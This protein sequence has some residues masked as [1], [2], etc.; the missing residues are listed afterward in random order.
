[1]TRRAGVLLEVLL[2]LAVF[3]GASLTLTRV[4]SLTLSA[5]RTAA[6]EQRATDIARTALSL[7]EIGAARPETL[8]GPADPMLLGSPESASG[9]GFGSSLGSDL[10]SDLGSGLGSGL[11]S[12]LGGVTPAGIGQPMLGES[13]W[14]VSFETERSAYPGLTLLAV[15]VSSAEGS[16]RPVTVTLFELV[17]LGDAADGAGLNGGLGERVSNAASA[18]RAGAAP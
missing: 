16:P 3:V 5:M 14:D 7:I 15:T 10:G 1:M 4:L 17:R 11:G 9:T 2:A 8:D 18:A 13:G 12:D 6:D